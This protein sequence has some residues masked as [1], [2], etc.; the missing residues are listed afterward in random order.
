MTNSTLLGNSSDGKV[1]MQLEELKSTKMLG[2]AWQPSD[3][4]FIF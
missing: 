1:S 4:V 2:L 3:D